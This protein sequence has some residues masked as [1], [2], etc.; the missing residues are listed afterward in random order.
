MEN[1]SQGDA[2]RMS[3]PKNELRRLKLANEQRQ[4]E[5]PIELAKLGLK[6]TLIGA[7]VGAGLV[8]IIACFGALCDKA[9][10]TGTHL[11]VLTGTVCATVVFYGAF[12][13]NRSI[14]IAIDRAKGVTAGSNLTESGK[15][16][17]ER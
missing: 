4:I 10:I 13:F 14:Q 6:G 17:H 3:D 8:V 16:A 15:T 2:Y 9:Q 12:V 7:I 5:L 1:D 11:C